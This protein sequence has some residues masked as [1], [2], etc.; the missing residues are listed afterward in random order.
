MLSCKGNKKEG[1]VF[2]PP[3]NLPGRGDF[4]V[5][6]KALPSG[7]GWVG[8]PQYLLNIISRKRLNK[9]LFGSD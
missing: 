2:E 3:L 5:S 8:L 6:F 7:E 9:A 4:F 1:R